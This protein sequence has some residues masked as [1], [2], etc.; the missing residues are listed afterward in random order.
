ME[1]AVYDF[2]DYREFLRAWITARPGGGHGEK[3]RIAQAARCHVA[4]ISQV[5]GGKADFSFEQGQ[6]LADHLG[7]DEDAADFLQL[8]IG[9]SRAGTSRLREAYARKIDKALSSRKVLKERF[10]SKS[11]V[12]S[13][14]QITYFSAWYYCV[15]HVMIMML[16]E[17]DSAEAIQTHLRLPRKLVTKTIRFLESAGLIVRDGKGYS[18][19]PLDIHLGT[20]S[21]MLSKHHANWRIA[22]L[23]SLENDRTH[24]LHYSSAVAMNRKDAELL[25]KILV[26]SID[27]ARKVIEDSKSENSIYSF[28]LDLFEVGGI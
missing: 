24:D 12:S 8:L 5:L 2:K 9:K 6:D 14:D 10:K 25:R 17:F 20:D 21:G 27:R 4:Y 26:E 13:E 22:A 28:S 7:L 23:E 3:S 19:G 15:I 1:A 16:P 11:A 18:R